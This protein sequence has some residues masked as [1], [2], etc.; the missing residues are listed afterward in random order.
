[1]ID[2][3]VTP[4]EMQLGGRLTTTFREVPAMGESTCSIEGCPHKGFARGWCQSHYGAWRRHGDPLIRK[5][6]RGLHKQCLVDGCPEKIR[7]LGYCTKHMTIFQRH[8][9]PLK[10]V[11]EPRGKYTECTTDGCTNPP[12][13]RGL[14]YDHYYPE[15]DTYEAVHRKIRALRGV[16]R[17]LPC[18][19]CGAAAA[20][21]SYDHTDPDAITAAARD[22]GSP[23]TYSLDIWRYEPRCATCHKRFDKEKS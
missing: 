23:V 16:A 20:H 6:Q 4:T 2:T 3:M 11:Y 9:D 14:C 18:V 10:T 5:N 1:M 22:T 17:D 21:W 7:G 15:N 19:N 8:G 13:A 12:L